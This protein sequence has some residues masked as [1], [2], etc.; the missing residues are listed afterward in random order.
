MAEVKTIA[1]MMLILS[2]AYPHVKLKPYTPDIYE[3][4]LGDIDDELLIA[5]AL[6]HA[7]KSEFFPSV[8]QLRERA[9]EI[10]SGINELPPAAEAWG[11]V[12]K[13][14]I[15]VGRN[16]KPDFDNPIAERAVEALGWRNLC[17]STNQV[18]DRARFIDVYNEYLRRER[19]EAVALPQIKQLAAQL[20]MPGERSG[21]LLAS[22][23]EV[24]DG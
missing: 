8:S 2:G 11:N 18:S 23:T 6:D 7:S 3:Q 14:M 10:K 20:R 17:L 19:S 16:G 12:V 9:N 13:L 22:E 1:R 5:A 15:N 4:L 24:N 21:H